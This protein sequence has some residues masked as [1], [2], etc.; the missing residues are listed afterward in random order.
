MAK[1]ENIKTYDAKVGGKKVRVTV[2]E[3]PDEEDALMDAIK[4]SMS[5][6][7]VAAIIVALD[8]A[9]VKDKDLR[10]QVTWY[11]NDLLGAVGGRVGLKVLMDE[12]G[13]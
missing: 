6:A 3:S 5:P 9:R 13:L 10:A 11:K 1:R 8:P 4:D 7:A 12:N 2:P